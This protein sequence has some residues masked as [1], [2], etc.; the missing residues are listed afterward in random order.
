M[1][2]ELRPELPVVVRA[3]D[4]S[5]F[6]RLS[7][8]GAAEVV[9]E[10]LESS[11]MLAS[12]A[13][14]LLGVPINRVVRRFREVREQRYDLLRGFFHGATDAADDLDEARPAAPACGDPG[15]GCL[16]HR[17]AGR[18]HRPWKSRRRRDGDPAPFAA[19]AETR[20]RPGTGRRRRRGADRHRSGS[21]GG[22]GAVAARRPE[23]KSPPKRACGTGWSTA[24]PARFI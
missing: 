13:L 3:A 1:V 19:G 6:D 5:D 24:R 21:D 10:T 4:E 8:A 16:G 2:R 22:R 15:S 18:E 12:H 17:L 14:V 7:L 11:I 9:P 23:V 20:T